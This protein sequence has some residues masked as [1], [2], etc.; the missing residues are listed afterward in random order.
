MLGHAS[1]ATLATG[2]DTGRPRGAPRARLDRRDE[3]RE[4]V[5][6]GEVGR[7]DR[8]RDLR[9]RLRQPPRGP[10]T[11]FFC[12]PGDARGRARLRRRRRSRP[13]R[14]RWSSS[15][16]SS[17]TC[18]QVL[19]ADARAAMAPLAARF[20]GDPTA[21]LRD[22]RASPAPTAR[23]PRPS[24][25]ARS[26]RRPGASTGLLGTVKQIVGGTEEEVVR[27]TP[28]A[29]DLQATFRRMLDAGDGACVMEVSSH[30]LALHRADAIRFDVAV[31]T[32]LTQDHL[33]FH[34]DMEDYFAAKRIARS[35]SLRR[36]PRSSTSTTP[37][38]P[39]SAQELG[40][41]HLLGRGRRGRLP[42]DRGRL[43]RRRRRASSSRDRRGGCRCGR[44]CPGTSTSPTRSARS[45]RRPRSGCRPRDAAA[46]LAA[47]GRVPGRFEPIDEGQAFAVLVDYAHTPDSLDNVLA[48]GAAAHRRAADLRLRRRRR[49]RPR[50]AAADGPGRRGALRP[51]G[52]HLRQPALRGAGGDHRGDPS[53]GAAGRSGVEVEPDRRAAIALA[54]GAGRGR[55]TPS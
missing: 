3:A 40:L 7:R 55:A 36:G 41:R 23:R 35:T 43:R 16:S 5:A 1:Y 6:V 45:P 12:V 39:A 32:N 26:S 8:R 27:T 37:T 30:A 22:G 15:A 54:L 49:P 20:F 50:Q 42:R 44:R 4:L 21:A 53:P 17:W 25:C 13:A 14:R 19:V 24:C 9:P 34:A 46:A 28:E 31:F 11:L 18:P 38:A 52:R 51:R 10:G 2:L 29:I 48:R 47:A 33:D